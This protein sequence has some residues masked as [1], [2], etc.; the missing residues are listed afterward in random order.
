MSFNIPEFDVEIIYLNI[1]NDENRKYILENLMNF[2]KL[3]VFDCNTCNLTELPEYLPISLTTL[4]ISFN[5]ISVLPNLKYLTSLVELDCSNNN[6]KKI[7]DELPDTLI[8][9]DCSNNCLTKLPN[10]S[11]SLINLYCDNNILIELPNLPNSLINLYCDNNILIKLPNLPKSLLN[12]CCSNNNLSFSIKGIPELPSNL[13]YFNCERN[14]L[15]ELPDL[16]SSLIR[17]HSISGNLLYQTYYCYQPDSPFTSNEMFLMNINQ[18]NAKNKAI[19]KMKLLDR[20]LLLEQSA[21][22]TMNPRRIK[23]LLDNLEIDFFDGSFD[24]LTS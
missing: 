14:K 1:F 12:L 9:L 4:D 2:T 22:I 17:F 3:K 10:L 8:T 5:K 20:T 13:E 6:L 19:K 11:N 16:S 23:R 21:K 15:T 18:T 7:S 24:T